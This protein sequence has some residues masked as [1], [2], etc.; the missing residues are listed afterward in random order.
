MQIKIR[1]NLNKLTIKIWHTVMDER[2]LLEKLEDP[3]LRRSLKRFHPNSRILLDLPSSRLQTDEV[4]S[5]TNH[6]H[7]DRVMIHLLATASF[8]GGTRFLQNIY[9]QREQYFYSAATCSD[10]LSL[11]SVVLNWGLE[12]KTKRVDAALE[13]WNAAG[14]L[15]EITVDWGNWCGPEANGTSL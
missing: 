9:Y 11:I 12:E 15:A 4:Q 6:P 7:I 8:N 1:I 14:Y 2:A 13:G 5:T 10:L 3:K